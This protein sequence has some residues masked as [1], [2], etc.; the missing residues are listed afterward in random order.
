MNSGA[1]KP[2]IVTEEN[3]QINKKLKRFVKAKKYRAKA[4]A[5]QLGKAL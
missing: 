1:I 2:C 4:I 3:K 5:L